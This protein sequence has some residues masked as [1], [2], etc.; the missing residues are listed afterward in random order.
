MT[1]P[2]TKWF[3]IG[4]FGISTVFAYLGGFA[5]SSFLERQIATN[6]V[7]PKMEMSTQD[8]P[9]QNNTASNKSTRSRKRTPQE[10]DYVQ[11]IVNRSIFDSTQAGKKSTVISDPVEG[12][13]VESSLQLTLLATIIAQP[14]KYSVALIQDETSGANTYGVG[15]DLIGQATITKI[16][17]NRVYFQ[18]NNSEQ[19][20]YIEIGGETSSKEPGT[21]KKTDGKAEDGD[22]Q[23]V[24][25]NKYVVDQSVL[26]EIL[27]NPEKLYT[28]VR[29]TP[30]KDADGNIDGYRMT[31][32]RRK[33]L[34][35]K[36]GIKNGDIV[37]SVNGQ[38][39]N[40]LSSAMDAYNSLGNSRDFNF[41]VTR[42]KNKQTFEYEVR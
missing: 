33:S 8:T 7:A 39:L 19:L 17:K 18:R 11:N 24:G 9:S 35:Y 26:D 3:A 38:Q 30:H 37:H 31:G 4:S 2:S 29:V 21:T 42:R 12:D 41:D 15:Y 10:R 32:I 36:L 14:A 20:E 16:E 25:N 5:G 23:K 1:T 40:S 28:Q 6:D 13:S 22:I 34:F 27:A